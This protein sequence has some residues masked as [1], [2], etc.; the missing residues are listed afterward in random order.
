M[1]IW[2]RSVCLIL[3]GAA[4]PSFCLGLLGL[5]QEFTGQLN[6][7]SNAFSLL[8]RE[9]V[10]HVYKDNLMLLAV[11]V[12]SKMEWLISEAV[13]VGGIRLSFRCY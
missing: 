12:Y 11:I 3:A 5:F 6:D 10:V 1:V 4:A 13:T 7:V 9:I 2:G 8:K